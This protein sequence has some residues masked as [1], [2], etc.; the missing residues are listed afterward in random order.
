MSQQS[1]GWFSVPESEGRFTPKAPSGLKR[2][3]RAMTMTPKPRH[4]VVGLLVGLLGFAAAVQVRGDETDVL[5]GARRDELLQ[6]LDG[7]TR[8]GDRLEDE[9]SEFENNKRDLLSGADS[10]EAARE[11]AEERLNRLKVLTGEVP[12][13]GPGVLIYIVDPDVDVS[14]SSILTAVEELRAAGAEA[15][16]IDG[17]NGEAVRVVVD[18]YFVTAHGDNDEQVG[19]DVAGTVLTPPYTI[20][21]IGDSATLASTASFPGGISDT[22]SDDGPN[23]RTDVTEVEELAIDV[24]HE[25]ADH[26]FARP[27]DEDDD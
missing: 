17:G 12:A 4:V 9:I 15:I 10:A 1:A 19:I 14:A 2:F 13:T 16:Q 23:A 22:V 21:A 20:A 3:W 7:L 5:E 24:L 11:Q 27:A 6:I 8:Q 25:P 26:E 18:T